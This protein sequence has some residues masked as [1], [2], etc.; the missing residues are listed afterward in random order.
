[1]ILLD[2]HVVVWLMTAPER[3]SRAAA[4][5]LE[6]R[7]V[8]GQRP[9]LSAASIFELGYGI[10][11]GR[12]L[13]H[14]TS[15]GFLDR[16]RAN[17]ELVPVTEAIAFEAASFPELSQLLTNLGANEIEKEDQVQQALHQ[18]SALMLAGKDPRVIGPA[19]E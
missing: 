14:G 16:M 17:F 12:I 9:A 10:R 1:M 18:G 13:M 11:R 15:I 7:G 6:D 8:R 5:A 3:I 4:S 2:T 19:E